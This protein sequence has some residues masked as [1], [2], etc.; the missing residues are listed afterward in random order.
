MT[1]FRS[2]YAYDNI[3]YHV[4]A[5]VIEEVSGLTW[6]D[7]VQSRIIE[8]L[9]MEDT[10]VTRASTLEEGNVATPHARIEG[11]V[12]ARRAARRDGDE[13]RRRNQLDRGRH[14]EM[15]DRAAGF[16][17]GVRFGA[18][19]LRADDDP[20]VEAGHSPADWSGPGG[21]GAAA[22]SVRGL[23]TGIR[24]AVTNGGTRW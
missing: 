12:T 24:N 19:L 17:Q 15:A 4:A 18:H 22:G 20:A 23:C 3:L 16:R 11:V 14:G 1:S 10:R 7:F 9:G 13:R 8:P 2:A 21:P 6:E 5:L